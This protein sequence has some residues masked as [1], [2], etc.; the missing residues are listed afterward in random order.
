[1]SAISDRVD[2]ARGPGEAYLGMDEDRRVSR[3][4]GRHGGYSYTT[5]ADTTIGVYLSV[6]GDHFELD[7]SVDY[8]NSEAM[9]MGTSNGPYK[10][11]QQV[12]S[13]SYSDVKWWWTPASYPKVICK[14]EKWIRETGFYNPGKGWI[15]FKNGANVLNRDGYNAFKKYANH[16]Y[17][18]GFE[19]DSEA[20]V[21]VGHG[22]DDKFGAA[23][24]GIGVEADTAH[25]V[26]SEQCI[27]F[28][29]GTRYYRI[30]HKRSQI[31]ELWGN[32]APVAPPKGPEIFYNY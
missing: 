15:Y 12:L 24:L 13:L 9:Q 31:H 14:T 21:S 16:R 22:Y 3:V 26:D 29:S 10:A 17:W 8:S 27:N 30:R 23:V 25:S 11:Y 28:G 1:M 19:P 7:G 4:L 5:G 2:Q 6:D 18:N 20:C 32:T